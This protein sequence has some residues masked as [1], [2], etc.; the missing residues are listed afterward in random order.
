M[1]SEAGTRMHTVKIGTDRGLLA[2]DPKTITAAPGDTI[3]WVINKLGPHN[4]VFD[5]THVPGQ[6]KALASMLS[7]TP[8]LV[9]PGQT[10]TTRIPADAPAGEYH[11]HCTPHRGAGEAGKLIIEARTEET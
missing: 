7:R 11:F 10:H 9:N 3:E 2:F 6:D 4:V 8:L 5:P 1:T